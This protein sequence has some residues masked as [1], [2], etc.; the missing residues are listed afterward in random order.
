MTIVP[1]TTSLRGTRFEAVSSV[2]FLKTGAFDTQGIVSIPL[3]KLIRVLGT[4]N[5]RQMAAVEECL[6][7]WLGLAVPPMAGGA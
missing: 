3:A 1:H 4:L 6:F 2:S 7:H 5:Q